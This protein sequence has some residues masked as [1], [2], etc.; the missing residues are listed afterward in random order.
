M[1]IMN[2]VVYFQKGCESLLLNIIYN[3]I[4]NVKFSGAHKR[5][6]YLSCNKY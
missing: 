3:Q 6:A 4:S 1:H 5:T 2:L